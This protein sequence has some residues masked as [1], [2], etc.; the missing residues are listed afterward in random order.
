MDEWIEKTYVLH[1]HIV[2]FSLFSFH[3]IQDDG[4]GVGLLCTIVLALTT[5]IVHTCIK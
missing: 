4:Y 3:K 2:F 5:I 1:V